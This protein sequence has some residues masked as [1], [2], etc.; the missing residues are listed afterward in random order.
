[1]SLEQTL[2]DIKDLMKKRK[3]GVLSERERAILEL[4]KASFILTDLEKGAV[5]SV[6]KNLIA[7]VKGQVLLA[8][9]LLDCETL[10]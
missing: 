1:M 3:N 9:L 10:S 5:D 6:K 8:S 2:V 7:E 4:R